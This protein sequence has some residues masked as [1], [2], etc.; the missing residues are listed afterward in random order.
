MR[1]PKK[2]QVLNLSTDFPH[3]VKTTNFLSIQ[4][5]HCNFVPRQFMFANCK[6]DKQILTNA[7]C[8]ESLFAEPGVSE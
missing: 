4:N 1:M 8:I 7:R 5:L 3:N 6:K 2:F